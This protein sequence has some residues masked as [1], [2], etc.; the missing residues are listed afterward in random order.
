MPVYE[1]LCPVCGKTKEVLK[2][3][4]DIDKPEYCDN[5]LNNEL[6]LNESDKILCGIKETRFR[7]ICG[8]EMKRKISKGSFRI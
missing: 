1:Y 2:G 4:K 8:W 5:A 6:L 3:I 7:G